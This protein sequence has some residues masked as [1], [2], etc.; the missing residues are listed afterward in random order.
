MSGEIRV[1]IR[2]RKGK[3]KTTYHLRWIDPVGGRWRNK[4][5]GTD[6][7][8]AEREAVRL[9][10]ELHSGTHRDVRR[11]SWAEFVDDHVGKIAGK[12]HAVNIRQILIEFGAMLQPPGPHAVT[13][14]MLE[15]F[16]V[17]LRE[18]GNANITINSKIKLVRSAIKSAV[19]RSFAAKV[20][21]GQ[22]LRL[23][24]DL[25]PPRIATDDE[26]T[27]LLNAAES[28]FGLSVR[29][30]VFVALNSG[31]RRG[32]LFALPWTRI[33]LDGP[34]PQIHFAETKGHRDRYVPINSDV[35][36]VLRKV[37][38]KTAF[39][40]GPFVDLETSFDYK[41]NRIVAEAGVDHITFHDLRSTYL[42]RLILAG[43]SLPV[44]QRL[45]GHAKIE[46]TIK[47]YVWANDSDLRAGVSKLKRGVG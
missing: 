31:G 43:V 42:T 46:T 7:R 23:P 2:K 45:A 21:D 4:R 17:K 11:I 38:L 25:K 35:V 39:N 30:M 29:A 40:E 5:I 28:L 6:K 37:Q 19:R 9:E 36:D 24:E 22:G 15:S 13:F 47:Y 16:V 27:K 3:T 44:V 1:W 18:K 41:W 8:L 14:P 20:P 33:K 32:E 26:E 34:K 12:H 10:D